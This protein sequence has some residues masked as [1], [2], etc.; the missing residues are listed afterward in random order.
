MCQR[1][2]STYTAP[3]NLLAA[4]T[5]PLIELDIVFNTKK[6]FQQIY[7]NRVIKNQL[8]KIEHLSISEENLSCMEFLHFFKTV[9]KQPD[10]ILL[11][12]S[13]NQKTWKISTGMVTVDS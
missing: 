10:K 4:L 12:S 3:I 1:K 8:Q 11:E 2:I 9:Y 5:I 7:L 13:N 6:K